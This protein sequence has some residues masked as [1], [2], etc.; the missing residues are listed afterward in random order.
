MRTLLISGFACDEKPWQ[1]LFP[2]PPSD[3]FHLTFAEQLTRAKRGDLR[4]LARET[5][6]VISE[7]KPDVLV[8]HDFGLTSGLLGLLRAQKRDPSIAPRIIFFDGAMRGFDIF[9]TRH[10]LR[11]QMMNPKQIKAAV[12]KAG[13]S[14]DERLLHFIPEIKAIYRQAILVSL[15][16]KWLKLLGRKTAQKWKVNTSSLIIASPNDLYTTPIC[17][18]FLAE[19]LE[20]KGEFVEMAYGHFP[21]SVDPAPIRA[22]IKAFLKDDPHGST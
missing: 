11:I 7:F 5:S 9:K 15:K 10:P 22:A 4:Q 1:T 19:D 20:P 2:L 18:K 14:F 8:L 17:L 12:L 6:K 13:G 16:E 21:Y 3:F